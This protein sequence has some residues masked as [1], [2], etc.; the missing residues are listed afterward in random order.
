MHKE[1]NVDRWKTGIYTFTVTAIKDVS[2]Y[3]KLQCTILQDFIQK[4]INLSHQLNLPTY[5]IMYA[6]CSRGAGKKN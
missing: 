5:D 1:E 4:P 3:R 2:R 6:N